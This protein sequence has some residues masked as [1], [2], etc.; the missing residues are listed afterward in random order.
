MARTVPPP[1]WK[2]AQPNFRQTDDSRRTVA[3]NAL[4]AHQRQL[5]SAA[6]TTTVNGRHLAHR[7]SLDSV[8]QLLAVLTAI[9]GDRRR[10]GT[11]LDDL[12]DVGAGDE[13]VRLRRS[14]NDALELAGDFE[15]VDDRGELSHHR[16]REQVDPAVGAVEGDN[17]NAVLENAQ[18]NGLTAADDLAI[19]IRHVESLLYTRWLSQT[20][21]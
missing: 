3:G 18:H 1:T 11:R 16:R 8:Q 13:A 4:I 12:L 20:R 7:E 9:E 10:H 14:E 6:E 5:R 2:N 19:D 17:G 15:L 21:R